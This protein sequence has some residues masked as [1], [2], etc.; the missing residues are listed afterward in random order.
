MFTLL[1]PSRLTVLMGLTCTIFPFLPFWHPGQHAQ[2][3]Q[4]F[5][6]ALTVAGSWFHHI[7][8]R[9]LGHSH[10][11]LWDCILAKAVLSSFVARSWWPKDPLRQKI[12]CLRDW[13]WTLRSVPMARTRRRSGSTLSKAGNCALPPLYMSDCCPLERRQDS[14]GHRMRWWK[15][16]ISSNYS[17]DIEHGWRWKEFAFRNSIL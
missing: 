2:N 6:N 15:L 14:V 16:T 11:N 12:L 5:Y 9:T 1:S 7:L 4:A 3:I 13:T 17:E 10:E 8:S